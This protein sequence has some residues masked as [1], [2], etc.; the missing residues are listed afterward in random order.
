MKFIYTYLKEYRLQAI[1]APLFKMLEATFELFVPLVVKSIIDVGLPAGDRPYILTRVGLLALLAAVGLAAAITAQYFSAKA[2]VGVATTLR[3]DLMHSVCALSYKELDKTGTAPLLTRLTSDVEAVQN[4]V[5]LTLR[6]LLRSPFVV[7]GAVVMAFTVDPPTAL[8]FAVAVPLMALAVVLVMRLSTPLYRR[9]QEKLEL[10]TRSV[11]ENLTGVRVLRAFS[12]EE[13]ETAAFDEKTDAHFRLAFAAG[14]LSSVLNPVTYVLVNFAVIALLYFGGIRV[15]TG[16]M[17]PGAVAAQYNYLTQILVELV[18]FANLVVSVSKALASAKRIEET[19]RLTSSLSEPDAP[20]APDFTA[21][22]VE[23]QNV[24]LSYHKTAAPA[25]SDVGFTV[26]PGQKIGVIGATGSGKT[27]L[28]NLIP[29]FYDVSAG[30]VRVFG[31]DVREYD[32]KTLLSLVSVAPQKATLVRGTVRENLTWG[33]EDTDENALSFAVSASASDAVLST[34][35]DGLDAAVE[36]GGKNFSGGQRQRLAIARALAKDAPILILDD[37]LSAL[38]NAT[39]RRVLDAVLGLDATVF[40]VSGRASVLKRCDKILVVEDG[41][42]IAQ[43]THD[44]LLSVCPAYRFIDDC[45]RG[46]GR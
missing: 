44:E 33:N 29:R 22:A 10:V 12:R 7:A 11:R 6:L 24:T 14:K 9:V 13:A 40:L 23:F 34:R 26:S 39:S 16:R 46:I 30:C 27:S 21:P 35:E 15:N 19:K 32:R 2:A 5:N 43:G 8:V 37:A 25:L 28:I 36:Q 45:E 3:S 17:T 42:L 1:L 20:A 18:K 4:G 38:D 41:A 31:R